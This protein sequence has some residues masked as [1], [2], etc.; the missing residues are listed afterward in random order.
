M[1]HLGMPT[2]TGI[3]QAMTIIH[4]HTDHIRW[5]LD[6]FTLIMK[7]KR[8]GLPPMDVANIFLAY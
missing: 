2:C 7:K 4:G 1:P 5:I 8:M 3:L 6:A